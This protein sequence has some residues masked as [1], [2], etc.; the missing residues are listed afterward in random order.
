MEKG[1]KWALVVE[2]IAN[3]TL[4]A[5]KQQARKHI[6]LISFTHIWKKTTVQ[7][8]QNKICFRWTVRKTE[9]NH[10]YIKFPDFYIKF[11]I[12]Q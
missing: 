4:R 3:A 6:P 8:F 9:K 2:I 11:N 12:I 1:H 10:F 5:V 7:I